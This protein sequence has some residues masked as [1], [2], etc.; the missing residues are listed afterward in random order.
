LLVGKPLDKI[1][2]VLYPIRNGGSL[3]R[4]V[5]NG[6]WSETKAS[7]HFPLWVNLVFE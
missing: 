1:P 6:V 4:M 3:I 2:M 7:D 5:D